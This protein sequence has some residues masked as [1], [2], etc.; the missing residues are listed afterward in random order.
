MNEY[1]NK[2]IE[3][4]T[5][6]SKLFNLALPLM[7]TALSTSLMIFFDRLILSNYNTH[8]MNSVLSSTSVI[9]IFQYSFLSLTSIATVFVGR[10][11]GAKKF[12]DVATPVWQMIWFS[13][14]ASIF[15]VLLGNYAGSTLL[16][17]TFHEEG[18]PY[19]RILMSCGFLTALIGGLSSFFIGTGRTSLISILALI[20]NAINLVLDIVLVFGLIPGIDA[21]GTAGAAL[22][23]VIAQA[24]Q[25]LIM[26]TIFLNAHNKKT[27]NTYDCRLKLKELFQY[28]KVG[29]PHSLSHLIEFSAWAYV[30]YLISDMGEEYVF[31]YSLGQTLFILFCFAS[32][33]LYNATMSV[34]S[35][36]IGAK[37]NH[38][39][40]SLLK[41]S[42][43][44]QFLIAAA[45]I[46]PC[47]AFPDYFI[48][49]FIMFND[50]TIDPSIYHSLYLTLFAIWLYFILDGIAWIVASIL[51]AYGHTISIMFITAIT[52]WGA[53]I[54]P[55]KLFVVKQHGPPESI[56]YLACCY[57][58]TALICFSLRYKFTSDESIEDKI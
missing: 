19:F 3:S 10:A 36:I 43:I 51:T 34:A 26:F 58:I 15:F 1:N 9:T 14:A 57:A 35:N 2:I 23:T 17:E 55:I 8:A 53:C 32:H 16:H 47:I 44:I 50:E 25:V 4:A 41:S 38:L 49:A 27:Y 30:V 28:L 42:I 6:P 13:L 7:L 45:L 56:W 48:N 20:A 21:M 5:S 39:I 12:H 37:S 52:A 18:L 11:Y 54:L 29:V 22:A 40:K 24:T 33:G 46:L 31:V